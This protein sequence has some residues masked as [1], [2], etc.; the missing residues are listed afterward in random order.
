V[1]ALRDAKGRWVPGTPSPNPGGRPA[2]LRPVREL[3][4]A[5]T[6]TA[7]GV[8][9]EIA[10]DPSQPPQA[11]I[12]AARTILEYGWGRPPQA[13]V[14]VQA[15]TLPTWEDLL[16]ALRSDPGQDA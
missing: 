5:K 2:L 10:Q 4:Q 9:V 6:E 16:E 12:E 1:A 3:A 14:E 8:L 11:R 7:V 15:R 13:T